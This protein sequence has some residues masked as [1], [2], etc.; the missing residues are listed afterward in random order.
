MPTTTVAALPTATSD[1]ELKANLSC[2][3]E[4]N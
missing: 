3:Y 2:L 4:L 1:R